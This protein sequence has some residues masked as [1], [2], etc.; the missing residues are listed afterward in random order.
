MSRRVSAASESNKNSASAFESCV[1]PT[2]VG[3]TRRKT[4]SGRSPACSPA[5]ET[6]TASLT[7]RNASGCPTTC[8][9]S[10]ASISSSFVF[11]PATSRAVG[12]PVAFATTSAMCAAVTRSVSPS[13][14]SSSAPSAPSAPSAFPS[15]SSHCCTSICS[16]GITACV[17]SPARPRLPSRSAAASSARAS[18]SALRA[19]FRGSRASLVDAH[20]SF[21]FLAAARA[22]WSS[23]WSS[24]RR[25]AAAAPLSL[26]SA[27]T[28]ICIERS[29]RSR[30]AMSSGFD[31]CTIRSRAAASSRRSIALSGSLRSVR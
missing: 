8:R 30:V 14:P 19:R 2:P 27:S 23:D 22:A 11:S 5:R 21:R 24:A 4:P 7:T 26:R 13:V 18:S 9:A 29:E 28:S 6:R 25:A 16:R 3:P 20:S 31:S 1:L 12:I 17:S 15:C 10:V